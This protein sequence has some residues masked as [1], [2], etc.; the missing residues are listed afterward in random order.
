MY[1]LVYGTD[2]PPIAHDKKPF[3]AVV[4]GNIAESVPQ[5]ADYIADVWEKCSRLSERVMQNG[6]KARELKNLAKLPVF[7]KMRR[8]RKENDV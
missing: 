2:C 6:I 8:Q 1:L 5:I 3:D 4:Q 7:L